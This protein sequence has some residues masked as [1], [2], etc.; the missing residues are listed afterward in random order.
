MGTITLTNTAAAPSYDSYLVK[1]SSAGNVLWAKSFDA[2]TGS[3]WPGSS[4]RPYAVSADAFGNIYVAGVFNCTSIT[5]GTTILTNSLNP[6]YYDI[7]LVKYNSNGTI[8]AA[9]SAGGSSDDFVYSA[10]T[11]VLGNVYLAGTFSSPSIAFG[12]D[13]LVNASYNRDALLLKLESTVYTGID[14]T[15]GKNIVD[16]IY[17]N[18]SDGVFTV[19][20]NSGSPYRLE[21]FNTMGQKVFQT[22]ESYQNPSV[23]INLS[24]FPKG[25]YFVKINENDRS[26]LIKI[27]VK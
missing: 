19:I 27:V 14:V 18:P 26:D 17:P 21:I 10:A 6:G 5:F 7:F 2:S 1:Y 11:D 8:L 13:T 16:I 15:E 3:V 20:D 24:A 4:G 25:I 12:S 9:K 22:S 23:E